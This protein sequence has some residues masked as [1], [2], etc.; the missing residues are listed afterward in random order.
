M[1]FFFIPQIPL[2]SP[3]PRIPRAPVHLWGDGQRE[4]PH[5][6]GI[7]WGRGAPAPLPGH[8]LQQHR[9]LPGQEIR[10][11]IPKS[12]D[13]GSCSKEIQ[14][15]AGGLGRE[16]NPNPQVLIPKGFESLGMLLNHS[17][18]WCLFP[19]PILGKIRDDFSL[20]KLR[21][22]RDGKI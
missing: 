3:F 5:H 19:K 7:S 8:D 18:V 21:C 1:G 10:A 22:V 4:D 13:N 17:V 6:D 14:P 11:C 9:P 15:G 2:I 12:L 20:W 16:K